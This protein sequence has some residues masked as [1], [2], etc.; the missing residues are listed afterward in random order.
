MQYIRLLLF[1]SV[2]FQSCKFQSPIFSTKMTKMRKN[3][4]LLQ[5]RYT[6]PSS[7]WLNPSHATTTGTHCPLRQVNRSGAVQLLYADTHILP[8][9]RSSRPTSFGQLHSTPSPLGVHTCEQPPLLF[10]HGLLPATDTNTYSSTMAEAC[11][12]TLWYRVP[13]T[14]IC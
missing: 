13:P 9:F 7:H 6:D 4:V 12:S 5:F 3:G 10:S 1:Y 14:L 8:S 2:I 11:T